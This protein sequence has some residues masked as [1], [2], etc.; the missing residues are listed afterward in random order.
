MFSHAYA[1]WV[2]TPSRG[3]LMTGQWGFRSLTLPNFPETQDLYYI[4]QQNTTTIAS[5][6]R[7]AGYDTYIVGKWHLAGRD[8]TYENI[9]HSTPNPL[10]VTTYQAGFNA[11]DLTSKNKY[12]EG[13]LISHRAGQSSYTRE[14]DKYKSAFMPDILNAKVVEYLKEKT[15]S[16]Q[17][18][19]L[20]YAMNLPHG[21]YITPPNK[22]KPPEHLTSLQKEKYKFQ[23]MI[24]YM[25]TLIGNV[26]N[27]L[28]RS[29]LAENTIVIYAGD[30]STSP[31]P[32]ITSRYRDANGRVQDIIGGKGSLLT[33]ALRVPFIV[34]SPLFANNARQQTAMIDFTDVFASILDFTNVSAPKNHP[35]DGISFAPLLRGESYRKREEVFMG[36]YGHRSMFISV[37]DKTWR[38]YGHGAFYNVAKDPNEETP[39]A[40]LSPKEKAAYDRLHKRLQQIKQD[41][42]TTDGGKS[43]TTFEALPQETIKNKFAKAK[44]APRYLPSE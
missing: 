39:L 5:S 12:Y 23:Q 24:S 14:T 22:T 31:T 42:S 30:N 34:W 8:N 29:G 7:D 44:R 28:E 21:R 43:A 35:L 40:N 16:K 41:A 9:T 19:F 25:D 1:N 13:E 15:Q 32:R 18:F 38:L 11:S 36:F 10:G 26:I 2:C 4:P 3:K 17:A 27:E 20:Y 6:L 33:E 37:F